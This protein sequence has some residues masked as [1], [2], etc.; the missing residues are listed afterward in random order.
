[1]HYRHRCHCHSHCNIPL[2]N[3]DANIWVSFGIG[4]NFAFW[5]CSNLG[6]AK[7]TALPFFHSSTGCD[8]TSGYFRRGKRMA[9]EA[10][11]S[12]PEITSVFFQVALQPYTYNLHILGCWKDI[13]FSYTIKAAQWN[14]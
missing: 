9:W 6:E 12:F 14:M 8:I 13:Q 2:F 1:M 3:S 10:W 7:S 4:K 5:N 11:N